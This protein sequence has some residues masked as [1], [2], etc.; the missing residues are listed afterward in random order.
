MDPYLELILTKLFKKSLD[1]NIFIGEEVRK[2][3]GFL[4]L[5]CSASKIFAF[6]VNNSNTKAIPIKMSI[7]YCIERVLAR[8]EYSCQILKENVKVINILSGLLIDGAWEVR[9]MV[10][11]VYMKLLEN[12][13][14]DI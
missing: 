2:C 14:E 13:R 1:T 6:V 10:R 7:L 3:M 4:C 5:Y 9:N 11:E 8:N 12:S